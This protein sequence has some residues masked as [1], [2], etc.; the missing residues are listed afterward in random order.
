MSVQFCYSDVEGGYVYP[1]VSYC[2]PFSWI[3][4][5]SVLKFSPRGDCVSS[6]DFL[7]SCG[8][9]ED[10]WKLKSRYTP[11]RMLQSKL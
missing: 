11:D 10:L 1:D 6:E 2:L 8:G 7:P 5:A 3:L 4:S 9:I